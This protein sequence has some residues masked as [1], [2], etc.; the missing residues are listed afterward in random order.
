MAETPAAPPA[1]PAKPTTARK[2]AG[3]TTL[4]AAPPAPA[5]AARQKVLGRKPRQN[6]K[7]TPPARASRVRSYEAHQK[8]KR[9]ATLRY[10]NKKAGPDVPDVPAPPPPR[11]FRRGGCT[12][13]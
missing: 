8:A 2:G 1:R 11:R 9:L 13:T 6:H 10:A 5:K 3:K 12:R 7:L 4:P